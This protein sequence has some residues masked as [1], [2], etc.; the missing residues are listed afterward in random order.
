MTNKDLTV[1]HAADGE[2]FIPS[3]VDSAE[4][5]LPGDLHAPYIAVRDAVSRTHDS[6]REM[7]A[8]FPRF[9]N[10]EK[11]TTLLGMGYDV[12]DQY[13]EFYVP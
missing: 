13:G 7:S 6:V 1:T 3:S 9:H 5:S 10:R 12:G 2:I 11:S 8:C 4:F